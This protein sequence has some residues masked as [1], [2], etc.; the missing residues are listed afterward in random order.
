MN[1]SNLGQIQPSATHTYGKS[2]AGGRKL[3][4]QR[5]QTAG[6][7]Y[8][9]ESGRGGLWLPLAQEG[10]SRSRAGCHTLSCSHNSPEL[11]LFG[12]CRMAACPALSWSLVLQGC[13]VLLLSLFSPHL[14]PWEG[15]ASG[16]RTSFGDEQLVWNL[17]VQFR[18]CWK[19]CCGDLCPWD[20]PTS[21]EDAP[22]TCFC[23]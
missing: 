4:L 2:R 15:N 1:K 5:L 19:L 23:V 11:G 8:S 12:C 20:S 22:K 7:G 9:L 21:H 18:Y 3:C 14:T 10:S 6:Q 17:D 13:S 16:V